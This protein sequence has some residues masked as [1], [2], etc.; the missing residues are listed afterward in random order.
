MQSVTFVKSLT[1]IT[2]QIDS[3]PAPRLADLSLRSYG[4]ATL[5]EHYRA[6]TIGKVVFD[7]DG[8]GNRHTPE[9]LLS[10]GPALGALQAQNI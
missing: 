3:A 2:A 10:D 1:A 8:K 9:T 4:S 6:D 7:V 5:Y